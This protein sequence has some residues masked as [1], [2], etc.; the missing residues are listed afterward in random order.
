MQTKTAFRCLN[1]RCKIELEGIKLSLRRITPYHSI[2]TN[3]M[4]VSDAYLRAINQQI[5]MR[6]HILVNNKIRYCN[7]EHMNMEMKFQAI[8]IE[9]SARHQLYKDFLLRAYGHIASAKNIKRLTISKQIHG[10]HN[11]HPISPTRTAHSTFHICEHL[12][13]SS[14]W[15]HISPTC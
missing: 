1:C 14:L 9:D 5:D 4:P 2:T 11:V 12:S 6:I 13:L 3:Y 15:H 10:H 8:N 7:E